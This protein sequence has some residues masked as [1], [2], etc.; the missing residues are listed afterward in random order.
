MATDETITVDGHELRFTH[1]D[2]V[3]YPS[4]G[5]TKRGVLDYYLA[6][7][8]TL[9]PLAADRPVTRKRWMEGVGTEDAPGKVFFHKDIDND[10]PNYAHRF[11]RFV[12]R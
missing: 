9:I 6:V 11:Y 5:L 10:A 3:V 7:A 8:P 4:T 1:P 2:K 12:L